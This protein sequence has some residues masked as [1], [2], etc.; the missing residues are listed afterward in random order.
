MSIEKPQ[1]SVP[2]PA[3][4]ADLPRDPRGYP[5][6]HGVW[7]NPET[8]EYDFRV[9]VE[10]I[11]LQALEERLC[12][13]S[14]KPMPEGE[15]W[16]IGGPGS[17]K[18]RS[19]ID[20]PMLKEVALYSL[21]VCPHLVIPQAQLRFAG[22]ESHHKPKDFGR[23]KMPV[24]MLGRASS[25]ELEVIDATRYIKAGEWL[26]VSWWHAGEQISVAEVNRM[27]RLMLDEKPTE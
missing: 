16:F 21:Q 6:P 4:L 25:Y 11:R 5:I 18:R 7:Q 19:F 2:L 9:I 22:T 15:Y 8:G 27:L 13:V 17:H 14:G 20:W 3:S 1:F 23:Q 26:E 12:A 24:Q 10:K